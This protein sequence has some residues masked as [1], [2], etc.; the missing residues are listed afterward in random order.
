MKRQTCTAPLMKLHK[1]CLQLAI[2]NHFFPISS[3]FQT[4]AAGLYG[5]QPPQ[6]HFFFK[7]LLLLLIFV[8]VQ[9]NGTV[10]GSSSTIQNVHISWMFIYESGSDNG[11]RNDFRFPSA[12]FPPVPVNR[13]DGWETFPHSQL[14]L[15]RF[16]SKFLTKAKRSFSLLSRKKPP[17]V[18]SVT[19]QLWS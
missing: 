12:Y 2:Y 14:L 11:N 4:W 18:N 9:I 19:C 17:D 16:D 13:K 10:A 1:Q 6:K 8:S 15:W 5:N 7:K 3:L